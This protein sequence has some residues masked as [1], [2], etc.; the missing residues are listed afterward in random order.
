MTAHHTL[1]PGHRLYVGPPTCECGAS[2]PGG[3]PAT[4]EQGRAHG[5]GLVWVCW[6]LPW[7]RR[8]IE[9]ETQPWTEPD[10]FEVCS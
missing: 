7:H 4:D 3:H 10:L 1:T 5:D 8:H 6:V 2:Y 9:A